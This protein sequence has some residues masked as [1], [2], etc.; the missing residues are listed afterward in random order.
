VTASTTPCPASPEPAPAFFPNEPDFYA[1]VKKVAPAARS[2]PMWGPN[3]T[4]TFTGSTDG[5]GKALQ[6]GGSFT[7]ALGGIQS[8]SVA[9][10]KKQGF[11]VAP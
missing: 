11:T 8:A 7:D 4:V 6:S 5:F 2:F 3:G 1:E 10:M 9:D